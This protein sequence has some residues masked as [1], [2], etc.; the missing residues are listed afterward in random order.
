MINKRNCARTVFSGEILVLVV[1]NLRVLLKELGGAIAQ[2]VSRSLPTAAA[3]V[4]A[5]SRHVGFVV[6]KVALGQVSSEYF[7]FPC[8]SLFHKIL[9]PHNHPGQADVTSG[10]SWTP[11]RQLYQLKKST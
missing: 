5:R 10:P 9:H 4:R 1:M 7:G 6:D 11:P 3:R 8:Q 2:A